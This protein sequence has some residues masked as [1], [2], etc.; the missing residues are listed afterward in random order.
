MTAGFGKKCD[1]NIASLLLCDNKCIIIV[2]YLLL[3]ENLF[4]EETHF[5]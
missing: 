2:E 4:H 5:N 3:N 1:N